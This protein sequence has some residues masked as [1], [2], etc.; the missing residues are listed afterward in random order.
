LTETVQAPMNARALLQVVEEEGIATDEQ[1]QLMRLVA[2]KGLDFPLGGAGDDDS[3]PP[4]VAIEWHPECDLIEDRGFTNIAVYEH[5]ARTIIYGVDARNGTLEEYNTDTHMCT[6]V[7]GNLVKPSQVFVRNE[8]VYFLESGDESRSNGRVSYYTPATR[9]TA[10][11]SDNLNRPKCLHVTAAY[12]IIFLE[13]GTSDAQ[14]AWRF[15]V[16]KVHNTWGEEHHDDVPSVGA[17]VVYG[18]MPEL[19]MLLHKEEDRACG[20]VPSSITL[21]EHE[22]LIMGTRRCTIDEGGGIEQFSPSN[23]APWGNYKDTIG[24][25]I[26]SGISPVVDVAM[27]AHGRLFM[28]CCG[29][30]PNGQVAAVAFATLPAVEDADS[31]EEE[32]RIDSG[33][34]ESLAEGQFAHCITVSRAGDIYFCTGV[35]LGSLKVMWAK[36][37]D[38]GNGSMA[39]KIRRTNSISVSSSKHAMAQLA[40]PSRASKPRLSM[41]PDASSAP[42]DVELHMQMR[43]QT[44]RALHADASEDIEVQN[45]VAV[46]L[47]TSPV[48]SPVPHAT[49]AKTH[50]TLVDKTELAA[51]AAI[52]RNFGGATHSAGGTSI[53]K[54]KGDIDAAEKTKQADEEDDIALGLNVQV[55]LRCR[56]LFTSERDAGAEQAVFA[57]QGNNEVTVEALRANQQKKQYTFDKVYDASISQ[58]TIYQTSILPIVLR[59]LQGFNCTVFA[60]GQT[61]AGKTYTMEGTLDASDRAGIIPR[62]IYTIFAQLQMMK[63]ANKGMQYEVSVSHLEI[64]NEELFDLL[65]NEQYKKQHKQRQRREQSEQRNRPA[66]AKAGEKKENDS[67]HGNAGRGMVPK[68]RRQASAPSVM[69]AEHE[70]KE[71]VRRASQ[72]SL[73]E[74]AAESKAQQGSNRINKGL[75]LFQSDQGGCRVDGLVEMPVFSADEIFRVLDISLGNRRTA[76]TLCNEHS[77]RSHSIF[78]IHTTSH[79]PLPEGGFLTRTGR[80]NLVDLSGSENIKRSGAVA[81]RQREAA[82]I[83]QG[84]LALGRVIKSIVEM[85]SHVPYRDS[86]LTRILEDSLGGNTMTTIILNVSPSSLVMDESASTMNYAFQAKKVLNTPKVN[87]K[88]VAG[89][90]QTIVEDDGDVDG[91]LVRADTPEDEYKGDG[92]FVR[93]WEGSVPIRTKQRIRPDSAQPSA[94][95]PEAAVEKKIFHLPTAEWVSEQLMV[96]PGP[97]HPDK[98]QRVPS[99]RRHHGP[100]RSTGWL[101]EASDARAKRSAGAGKKGKAGGGGGHMAGP[102]AGAMRRRPASAH[103]TSTPSEERN[104]GGANRRPASAAPLRTT[105]EVGRGGIEAGEGAGKGAPKSSRPYSAGGINGGRRSGGRN[106]VNRIPG[107]AELMREGQAWIKEE[108][109]GEDDEGSGGDHS[110]GERVEY[111]GAYGGDSG[112]CSSGVSDNEDGGAERGVRRRRRRRRP[113]SNSGGGGSGPAMRRNAQLLEALWVIFQKFDVGESGVLDARQTVELVALIGD[114]TIGKRDAAVL[115]ALMAASGTRK[116][117]KNK[118]KRVKSAPKARKDAGQGNKRAMSAGRKGDGVADVEVLVPESDATM[119]ERIPRAAAS[120]Q[121]ANFVRYFEDVARTNPLLSRHLLATHGFSLSLSR[122]RKNDRYPNG[123]G[124]KEY[125]AAAETEALAAAKQSMPQLTEGMVKQFKSQGGKFKSIAT[126]VLAAQMLVIDPFDRKGYNEDAKAKRQGKSPKAPKKPV[127]ADAEK[128]KDTATESEQLLGGS[129]VPRDSGTCSGD[130]SSDNAY[131]CCWIDIPEAIAPPP[132]EPNS[133]LPMRHRV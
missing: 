75:R 133:A 53:P 118:P 66:T 46:M 18:E 41:V 102:I 9:Q 11:V 95:Q 83:G 72:Q 82:S 81:D 34:W 12:D 73:A 98:N 92:K 104:P 22:D 20:G 77:S 49:F 15:N 17:A 36:R 35:G 103:P 116:K 69:R 111:G 80:V 94:I 42:L 26:S 67:S 61:G 74:R 5:Q 31:D 54:F 40:S 113:P 114:G 45:D 87:K 89:D 58:K 19:M 88:K 1:S 115:D 79:E 27:D 76:A 78:T 60:Y 110:E 55:L 99:A 56:P 119:Y 6:V 84:L 101:M 28:A 33:R 8:L 39:K 120:L 50:A 63:Q 13:K 70:E 2:E 125:Q 3:V 91:P 130:F 29:A 21:S 24:R 100:P 129:R 105:S 123:V 124:P 32:A 68:L 109:G 47:R 64:Y 90:G 128:D 43:K 131:L 127:E 96:G 23:V 132:E 65:D 25:S 106:T 7:L 112:W 51:A 10:I 44:M 93:P 71:R 4:H 30:A 108:E 37:P 126:S 14:S 86:K 52:Q 57:S 59:A 107:G 16:W 62:S 121:F 85:K 122:A 117:Q 48:S 97:Y 38:D